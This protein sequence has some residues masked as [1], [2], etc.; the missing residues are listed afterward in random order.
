MNIL[1]RGIIWILTAYNLMILACVIISFFPDLQR[2]K[3][4]EMLSRFV[5]PVLAPFRKI[6]PPVGNLDLTALVVMLLLHM[7]ITGLSRW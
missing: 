2:N 5:D 4:A 3:I 1:I 7:A 6:I